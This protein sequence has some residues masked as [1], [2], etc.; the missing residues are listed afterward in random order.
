MISFNIYEVE[1]K[2]QNKRKPI[3]V[4]IRRGILKS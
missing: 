3:V 1:D 2:I 4:L